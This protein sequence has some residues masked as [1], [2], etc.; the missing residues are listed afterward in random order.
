M[1]Y[2]PRG[3]AR[4]PADAAATIDLGLGVGVGALREQR[5][6]EIAGR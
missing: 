6:G 3:L 1:C 5:A 2:R 4:W